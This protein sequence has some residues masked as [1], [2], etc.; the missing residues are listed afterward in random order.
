MHEFLFHSPCEE[1][2]FLFGCAIGELLEPGDIL[3]LWG[4]L[5]AGKTLLAQGIARGLGIARETRVTS[6]TFTII[7]EY[8][9]GF[10][11]S[12]STSTGF[13]VPTSLRPCPGRSLFSEMERPSLNGLSAWA[14]SCPPRGGMSAFRSAVKKAAKYCSGGA[15]ARTANEWQNGSKFSKRCEPSA[16]PAISEAGNETR[17]APLG[18]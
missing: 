2:S 15:E 13:P 5:A 18:A 8:R 6:P 9:R 7:N 11:S 17:Q 10:A 3:A 4:E 16:V 14:A 12:T 1:C